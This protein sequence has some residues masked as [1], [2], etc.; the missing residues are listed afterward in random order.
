MNVRDQVIHSDDAD[1]QQEEAPG[2]HG[3][4]FRKKLGAAA[5]ASALGCTLNRIPAGTRSWPAHW[6][7]ANEE[8]IYVL[9][10]EGTLHVGGEAV[11]LR[12]GSYAA[13]P[14][15]PEHAH[16]VENDSASELLFLCFSTMIEPDV[17][18]YPD[19]NKVGVFVGAAPG[20]SPDDATLKRFLD[21]DAE[22]D[23]WKDEEK[24]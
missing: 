1:W 21:L 4:F 22:V 5:G 13:L 15:G 8:A 18:V 2:G 20:G 24:P 9:S 10:G 6:H 17:V 14:V 19:S 7:S 3:S 12:A 11:A 23:Y 16:R